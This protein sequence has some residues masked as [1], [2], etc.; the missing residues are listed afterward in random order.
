[1]S[2]D[3][4]DANSHDAVL[5]RILANQEHA[6]EQARVASETMEQQIRE[7][8]GETQAGFARLDGRVGALEIFRANL[9]GKVAVIS[10]LVG[11]GGAGLG[12]WL[13]AKFGGGDH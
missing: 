11:L 3:K 13:K 4:Y 12:E 10:S 1:M 9:K 5:S 6:A 8:R 7:L 2:G